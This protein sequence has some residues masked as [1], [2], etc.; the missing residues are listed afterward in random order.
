LYVDT[1]VE[2][3]RGWI[4]QENPH[5]GMCFLVIYYS[6]NTST[7]KDTKRTAKRKTVDCPI[8]TT[9]LSLLEQAKTVYIEGQHQMR[10]GRH[11]LWI[12][13]Y[14]ANFTIH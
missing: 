6:I 10:R 5:S 9:G 13:C 4:M 8:N 1:G 14:H 2:R 11:I 12:S 3:P 7:R